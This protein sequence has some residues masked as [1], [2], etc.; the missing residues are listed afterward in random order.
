M[1]KPVTSKR[2]SYMTNVVAANGV[3][4][5]PLGVNARRV[6]LTLFW[7]GLTGLVNV[8]FGL[9][10][11]GGNFFL[12]GNVANLGRLDFDID[13]WGTFIQQDLH[14]S[15]ASANTNVCIVETVEP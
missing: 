11:Q 4:S 9:S 13:E 2:K 1:D 3:D 5:T 15:G 8:A 7:C 10:S 14:I 6:H 12:L